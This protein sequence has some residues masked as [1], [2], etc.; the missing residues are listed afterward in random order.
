MPETKLQIS[1]WIGIV[2]LCFGCA[3]GA[4]ALSTVV[5][6]VR[7]KSL[8]LRTTNQEMAIIDIRDKGNGRDVVLERLSTE[9]EGLS[10]TVGEVR[11]DVKLLL[12][13]P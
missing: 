12:T 4:W 13:R 11:D 8:N 6:N 10:R 3:T 1:A 7:Y 5:Q 9:V 2:T